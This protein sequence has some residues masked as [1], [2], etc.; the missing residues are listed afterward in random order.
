MRVFNT[1]TMQK[2]EFIPINANEVKIYACGPTVYNFFHIGN[3]RPFI[4]FDVLRRYLEYKGYN[5][6][7]VQN[8]TDIDDK[9]IK[10]AVDE[11]V[12]FNEIA[13]RYI[14]EYYVD[15]KGLGVKEATVHPKATDCMDEIIEIIADLIEKGFAYAV[16]GDVYFR[17]LKFEEYGKLSKQ[18]L[19]D[20]EIGARIEANSIKEN[21]LDFAVWKNA[22]PNEPS[23]ETPWGTGR[24][25]WHIECSAMS[26]KYLGESIDIHCGGKDLAFPHHENEIAQSECANGCEYA[27]YWMHNGFITVDNQK[28]SK[29]KG[30]FFMVRE[31]SEVY[32]YEAIRMFMLASHYRSPIN[33]SEDSLVQAKSSLERIYNCKET[34][35]FKLSVTTNN[36]DE[37]IDFSEFKIKFEKAMDDD[38]NT[39]DAI[40][41]I[42]DLVRVLNAEL[43]KENPSKITLNAGK[44]MLNELCAVINLGLND[45]NNDI[46]TE[47]EILIAKRNEARANKDF[48]LS[49]KIR[50]E[51]LEMGIILKDTPQ[52]VSWSRK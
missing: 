6:N 8:F 41:V 23:W 4:I 52:G 1:L 5:V 47:I 28:M 16:E 19:D 25:G 10:K 26:R 35:E 11:G 3:A 21:P 12:S 46:D 44:T 50:D 40:A 32:G 14:K 2:E 33:Y 17:S 42:F 13:D 43:A 36:N 39:A 49:D 18:P 31:A 30:N 34:L 7:F 37:N 48:A 29:S 20:L 27:K 45:K 15:A 38:L 22:K 9:V 24:P 51:L